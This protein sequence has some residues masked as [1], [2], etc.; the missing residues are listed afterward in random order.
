M[1]WK[2]KIPALK[3]AFATRVISKATPFLPHP[4]LPWQFIEI[5]SGLCLPY[6][7][8]RSLE[9][10]VKRD[11]SNST[12]VE[13]GGGRSTVWWR[14]R[15]KEVHSFDTNSW[16]ANRFQLRLVS[17]EDMDTVVK[18]VVGHAKADVVVIDGE[19]VEYRDQQ[20]HLALELLKRD[21]QSFL[22]VDNFDQPSVGHDFPMIKAKIKEQ[23]VHKIYASRWHPDWKT[24]FFWPYD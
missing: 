14:Y 10:L 19:P 8:S 23:G 3:L 15:A 17:P 7:T 6:Y 13:L 20:I 12:V 18:T 24:L 21:R 2:R 16:W 11:F 1:S 9:A 5:D 22:I 4:T